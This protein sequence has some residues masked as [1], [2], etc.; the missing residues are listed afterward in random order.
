LKIVWS[1]LIPPLADT[2]LISTRNGHCV[3]DPNEWRLQVLTGQ[4]GHQTAKRSTRDLF[5]WRHNSATN[6]GPQWQPI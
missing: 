5:G 1:A 4:S 6:G 3:A 2:A